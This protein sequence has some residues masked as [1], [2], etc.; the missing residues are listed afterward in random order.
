M[1]EMS[2]GVKIIRLFKQIM[3]SVKRNLGDSFRPLNLTGPQGMILGTLCRN[4]EMKISDLSTEVGLSNSTVS[5]I[6]DRLEKQGLAERKRSE[7]DRRV[8]YVDASPK[9][10]KCSQEHFKELEERVAAIMNNATPEELD[11]VLEGMEILK[12]II[13][14]QDK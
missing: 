12:K 13:E 2:K 6:I 8:V 1:E 9:F 4:G 3:Q 14:R 7:E 11:K 5:G 10:K